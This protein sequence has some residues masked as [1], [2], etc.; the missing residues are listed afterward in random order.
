ML[1]LR[2]DLGNVADVWQEGIETMLEEF[3]AGHYNPYTPRHVRLASIARASNM[4]YLSLTRFAGE[5]RGVLRPKK[6]RKGSK[7]E[8]VGAGGP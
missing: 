1:K 5:Q 8:S 4:Q 3:E 6:C 2:P 7:E